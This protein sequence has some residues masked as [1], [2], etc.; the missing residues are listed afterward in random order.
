MTSSLYSTFFL[1]LS[2]PLFFIKSATPQQATGNHQVKMNVLL[3]EIFV[4]S[5]T[6]AISGIDQTCPGTSITAIASFDSSSATICLPCWHATDTENNEP[7]WLPIDVFES[8][9]IYK[10][11]APK[12]GIH[13]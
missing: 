4:I 2:H 5:V 8:P 3:A 12:E 13:S 10:V 1:P 9:E 11:E 6:F 7:V